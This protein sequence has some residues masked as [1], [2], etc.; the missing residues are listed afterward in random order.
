MNSNGILAD[1]AIVATD[2]SERSEQTWAPF[3]LTTHQELLTA[4]GM[5][6]HHYATNQTLDPGKTRRG[7]MVK[8]SIT[9]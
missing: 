3:S 8:V 6:I 5:S 9:A 7:L 1:E 2:S 4:I